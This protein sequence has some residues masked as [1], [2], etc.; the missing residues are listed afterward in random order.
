MPAAGSSAGP[1]YDPG[2]LFRVKGPHRGGTDVSC[3]AHLQQGRH[4][5]FVVWELDDADDVVLT[6]SPQQLADPAA[7]ALDEPG[8]I[9]GALSGIAEVLDALV[10]P[11]DQRHICRHTGP[12]RLL[13]CSDR[14][15]SQPRE[16]KS[17]CRNSRA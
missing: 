16:V 14:N 13:N 8:E 9:L 7:D 4:P 3:R 5:R 11:V 6:D 1:A 2:H 17:T 12:P 10:G 15:C